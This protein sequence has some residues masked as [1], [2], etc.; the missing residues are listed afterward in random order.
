MGGK[1]ENKIRIE[2]NEESGL[3]E[4]ILVV[5]EVDGDGRKEIAYTPISSISIHAGM[6]V[7]REWMRLMAPAFREVSRSL[8]DHIGGKQTYDHSDGLEEFLESFV[9]GSNKGEW[10]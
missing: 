8:V 1:F 6:R 4:A 10:A 2:T 9:S 7:I 5:E 3:I